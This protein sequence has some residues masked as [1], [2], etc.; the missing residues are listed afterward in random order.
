MGI[1]FRSLVGLFGIVIPAPVIQDNIKLQ[2]HLWVVVSGNHL[3]E[4][5]SGE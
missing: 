2:V 3:G 1:I 4:I 5:V